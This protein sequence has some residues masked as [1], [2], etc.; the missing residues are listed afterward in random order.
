MSSARAPMNRALLA[1]VML[2]TASP[3]ARAQ[4]PI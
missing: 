2:A 1:L 3:D 4:C